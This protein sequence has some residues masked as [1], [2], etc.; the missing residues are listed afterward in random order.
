MHLTSFCHAKAALTNCA[1]CS[2]PAAAQALL[3]L[4]SDVD[5]NLSLIT[6][7]L[8]EWEKL[9][10]QEDLENV[11]K[12]VQKTDGANTSECGDE[13]EVLYSKKEMNDDDDS[14]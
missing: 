9:V 2:R 12:N 8:S 14:G 3:P 13:Q 11:V 7:N 10:L 6:D 5:Q 1:E 4:C